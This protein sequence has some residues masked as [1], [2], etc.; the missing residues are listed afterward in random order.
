MGKVRSALS[1]VIL[2]MLMSCSVPGPVPINSPLPTA[3]F[4]PGSP[5]ASADG[6]SSVPLVPFHI[7]RPLNVGDTVVT[8]SG[9]AGIPIV[10]VSTTT[11]GDE[12]GSGVIGSDGKFSVSVIPLQP[13]VRI[14][15][16]LGD[17][18]GTSYDSS[19]FDRNEFHGQEALLVPLVGFFHDTTLVEP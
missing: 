10:I 19:L 4:L 12:L 5:I 6:S 3:E 1:V 16:A 18:S 11:M 2:L 17:L 9:P 15:L 7:D 8:G 14:G 13:N